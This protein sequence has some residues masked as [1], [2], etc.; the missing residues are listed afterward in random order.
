MA[1]MMCT[2]LAEFSRAEKSAIQQRLTSG[3]KKHRAAGG[4]V[5]RIKGVTMESSLMLEKHKETVKFLKKGR[6]IR[7]TALL[8]KQ[9]TRT[10]QKVKKA[11]VA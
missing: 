9:S 1:Q 8:V 6:S 3:Y 7:E 10:V 11:M 5:G 2:M 4:R